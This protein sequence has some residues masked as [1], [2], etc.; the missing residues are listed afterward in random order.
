MKTRWIMVLVMT[1]ATAA[2]AE[3]PPEGAPSPQPGADEEPIPAAEPPPADPVV[4]APTP[5]LF[6]PP[7]LA[8]AYEQA[9][10]LLLKEQWDSAARAFDSIAAQSVEPERRGAAREL[11]RFAREMDASGDS[12]PKRSSGRASFVATS[13]LAAFYSSFVINDI[14]GIDNYKTQTLLVTGVTLA[15]FAGALFGTKGRTVTDSMAGAYAS[16]LLIGAGNG[17]LL[18]PILGID[19]AADCCDDG[20]VNQNYLAFGL[21]AMIAGGAAA[22]YLA[23]KYDP[24]PAQAQFAG[25]MGMNGFITMG[26]GLVLVQPELELDS[27]LAILAL[28]LEAGVVGGVLVGRRLTWSRSRLTYVTLAEFLG[29]LVAG[30]LAIVTSDRNTED[31]EKVAAGM[32]LG[33]VW[34]GF[35]L[36]T[37]LTRDMAPDPRY[38]KRPGAAPV[39]VTLAP[40]ITGDGGRGI[41]LAGAF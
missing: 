19:A 29:G 8:V 26:L 12:G 35:G 18:A 30:A 5:N 4:T 2:R 24:T 31:G 41:S 3:E 27:T 9:F 6:D 37:Y 36:A 17:L 39:P 40:M 28:G 13:T 34:G 10:A 22:T 32:V 25:V 11:A 1:F 38:R 15:G 7:E 21:G 16:G 20:E 23:Y 33:G 14:A